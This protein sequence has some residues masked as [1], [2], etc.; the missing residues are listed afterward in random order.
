MKERTLRSRRAFTGKLLRVD[1]VDVKLDNGRCSVREM[2]RHP[3]A[4]AVLAR[5]PDRRFLLVRQF[6]KPV[7]QELLEV[8]A[9][10]LDPGETPREC[11]VR[12]LREETGHSVRSIQK[13]G[14]LYLAPGYSN[15]VLHVFFAH[16]RASGQQEPDDDESLDAIRMTGSEIERAIAGGRVRDSKTLAVWLLYLRRVAR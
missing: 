5:C 14:V 3:G 9:G 8:V 11:A 6:R 2:V 12:E 1:V 13:L 7:E 16:A 4:V 10:T 15:E